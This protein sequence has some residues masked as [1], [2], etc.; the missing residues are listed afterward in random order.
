M[1]MCVSISFLDFSGDRCEVSKND[2]EAQKCEGG[3]V[4]VDGIGAYYCDC[5][6]ETRKTGDNCNKGEPLQ[7]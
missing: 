2:C 5:S 6:A 3:G 4:C 1:F 7:K